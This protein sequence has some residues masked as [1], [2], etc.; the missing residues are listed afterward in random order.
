MGRLGDRQPLD[1][2]TLGGI[3]ARVTEKQRGPSTS[4]VLRGP[5]AIDALASTHR[6]DTGRVQT[7]RD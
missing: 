1:I 3:I 2:L 5:P 4:R 7:I 6:P